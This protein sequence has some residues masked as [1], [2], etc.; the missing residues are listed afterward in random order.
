ME[1]ALSEDILN[2][3]SKHISIERFS[4]KIG[5]DLIR[6]FEQ[7]ERLEEFSAILESIEILRN[8][9]R[10]SVLVRKRSIRE[11]FCSR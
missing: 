6:L 8:I 3:I 2:E 7:Y 11:Y 10:N 1:E 5:K 9:Q 4:I